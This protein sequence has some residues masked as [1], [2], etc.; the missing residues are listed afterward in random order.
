M[1]TCM[2]TNKKGESEE[3]WYSERWSYWWVYCRVRA[4]H[5]S[6]C[7]V[8]GS[9]CVHIETHWNTEIEC[10]KWNRWKKR[11]WVSDGREGDGGFVTDEGL[12][13]LTGKWSCNRLHRKEASGKFHLMWRR[14]SELVNNCQSW[15]RKSENCGEYNPDTQNCRSKKAARIQSYKDLSC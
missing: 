10:G 9:T 15:V 11:V 3:V 6:T 5:C 14:L 7:S 4:E 12:V 2:Q 8:A 13:R 1:C